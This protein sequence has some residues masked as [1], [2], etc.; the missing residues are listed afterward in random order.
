[1][2]VSLAPMTD[3]DLAK[4]SHP[5]VLNFPT[6]RNQVKMLYKVKTGFTV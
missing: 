1:M 5:I 2:R 4:G 3:F 6:I